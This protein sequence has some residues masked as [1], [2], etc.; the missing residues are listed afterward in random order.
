MI[1]MDN[2]S[3]FI[4]ATIIL[5]LLFSLMTGVLLANFAVAGPPIGLKPIYAKVS[6][7]SPQNG[8]EDNVQLSFTIKTNRFL[9]SY[10]NYSDSHCFIILDSKST[11]F[12][13]LNIVGQTTIS[14]DDGYNPYTEFTLIGNTS[15]SNLSNLEIGTHAVEVEY[16]FYYAWPNESYQTDYIVLSS[17]YAQFTV[18]SEISSE[19]ASTSP[20]PT[21]S[22]ALSP[23]PS[24]S[25]LTQQPTIEP[26]Q[27]ANPTSSSKDAFFALDP[28]LVIGSIVVILAVATVTLVYLKKRNKGKQLKE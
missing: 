19:S 12:K 14:N 3:S 9:Q 11:E 15:L 21:P 7:E 18:N 13:E 25:P 28:T 20:T 24:P 26:T 6:I 8:S 10:S 17:A 4:V 2:K 16:G 27:S 1:A 22:P 5:S 23:S